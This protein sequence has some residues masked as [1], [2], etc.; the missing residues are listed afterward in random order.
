MKVLIA[1]DG[2]LTDEVL[3]EALV[4]ELP[5]A[6][7]ARIASTWPNPPFG[8]V[9]DVIEA[10]GDEDELIEALKGCDAVI[11]HT[12][13]FTEK[14]IAASP[15]LKLITIC[16]G[17]PVNVNI[18]AATR[19][20]VMV[21]YAPGR[22]ARAT[23]EHSV[24]MLLAAARQIAQRHQEVVNGEWATDYYLFEKAGQEIGSSTVGIIGY[25]A[26]G[27]RVATIMAAFGARVLVYDPFKEIGVDGD[28]EFVD[29]DTLLAES[30][31]VTIHARVTDENRHMINAETLGKM[32]KGAIFVNCARGSLVDYDAVCDS[33]DAGH[34]RAAAFDCLPEEPL[35]ADH[36]LLRTPR[37]TFTPHLAGASQEA[38]RVAARIGTADIAAVSRGELPKFLANPEVSKR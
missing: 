32:K 26:I 20:G 36:R 15:D 7:I 18:D 33:I 27:S 5:D 22:N 28:V 13:P 30:D 3:T 6:E 38:S 24:A 1:S 29:F 16:R 9:G 2:F 11:S 25:G 21:S 14:V 10:L 35:P 31:F 8:D 23:A 4:N 37:I 34:L 12:F 19:H 17:G